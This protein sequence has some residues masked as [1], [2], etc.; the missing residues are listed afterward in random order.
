MT[1]SVSKTRLHGNMSKKALTMKYL[2]CDNS[3]V[4]VG[5]NFEVKEG[6][7]MCSK[8]VYRIHRLIN[9]TG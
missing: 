2:K 6:E 8:V 4:S 3:Y 1:V 5:K 7:G 9:T